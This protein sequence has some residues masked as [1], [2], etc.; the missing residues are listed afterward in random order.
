MIISIVIP[1]F[2]G[3]QL[4]KN[5]LPH[6]LAAQPDEIIVVDDSSTDGSEQVLQKF[7]NIKVV[8]HQRNLGFVASVN[9]G[10]R[11]A[12]GEIVV[13]LN[14]DVSPNEDF[15]RPL[16]KHFENKDVFAVSCAEEGYS[17]AWAKFENGFITHGMGKPTISAH[18][19]FWASGGS[20]AFSREK[21]VKL[22][23]MD[24]LYKPFYWEDIDICYRA[25]KR[26]WKIL[27]E[28]KSK[29]KHE[30]EFTIAKHFSRSYM[31]YISQRNQ[32]LF[33]WKNITDSAMIREHQIW[34]SKKLIKE[35][36]YWKVFYSSLI[37]LPEVLKKRSEEK[38]EEVIKN[39]E[40]FDLFKK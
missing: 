4:L 24:E 22:D 5:N 27:W 26:G 21:W 3:E 10:V 38:K 7:T 17:W 19:S 25:Q 36:K 40:I 37:K 28:P 32:L 39:K 31:D 20:A 13:L 18:S 14:N 15:L 11:T 35:P 1:N 6:V 23:G 33:I 30:H 16:T 34:L 2:N 9:D 12:K 8:K 29:V